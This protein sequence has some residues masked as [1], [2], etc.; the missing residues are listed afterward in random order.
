MVAVL[1]ISVS[2]DKTA[3]RRFGSREI[4]AAVTASGLAIVMDKIKLERI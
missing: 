3:I 1:V 2:S 4:Y